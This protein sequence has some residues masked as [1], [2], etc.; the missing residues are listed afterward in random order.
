M[1]TMS[2]ATLE[3]Q[4]F[5]FIDRVNAATTVA[6]VYELLI[7][8]LKRLGLYDL[9]V[10][11]PPAEEE[12][13]EAADDCKP[14]VRTAIHVMCTCAHARVR[15]ILNLTEDVP[16]REVAFRLTAREREVLM[17][18]ARGK[19][20]WEIGEI[21]QISKETSFAHV[22]NC[23]RKLDALTRTQAVVRA[24]MTGEIRP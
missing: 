6:D 5:D 21:L 7:E 3:R 11:A 1:L 14:R 16:K 15:T 8:E 24:M 18:V 19:T 4:T 2:E 22:R 9:V 12:P 10:G 20:D 13:R 17:W 23:C